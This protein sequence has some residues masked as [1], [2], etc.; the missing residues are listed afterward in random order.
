MLVVANKRG[1]LVMRVVVLAIDTAT[2]KVLDLDATTGNEAGWFTDLD[3]ANEWVAG[4]DNN[5]PVG[6]EWLA[7]NDLPLTTAFYLVD[8]DKPNHTPF[9]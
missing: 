1:G 8:L 4:L 6:A 5:L 3:Y 7:D 9:T 2:G